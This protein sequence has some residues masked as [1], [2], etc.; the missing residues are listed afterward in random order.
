MH[1][2]TLRLVHLFNQELIRQ[3]GKFVYLYT[4]PTAIFN[5]IYPLVNIMHYTAAIKVR[6]PVKYHLE[7]HD[8]DFSGVP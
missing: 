8:A 2:I 1:P 4:T 7:M 3:S 6:W 5:F